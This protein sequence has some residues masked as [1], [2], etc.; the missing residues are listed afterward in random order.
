MAEGL[1]RAIAGDRFESHSAGTKPSGVNP[2]AIE[3]MR[4]VGIDISTQGSKNA[5]EYLGTRFPFIITVCDNAKEHC[6]IFPGPS[7]R[8][9]WSFEDP[10]DAVGSDEE[11][12]VVF[13][14]V[15]DQI[16]DRVREFVR[17]AT[18]DSLL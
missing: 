2:L 9:H 14:K 7:A 1:L 12:M 11:R 5:S 13:R 10:A 4:E 8:H 6:P 18:D 3:A 15:R 17:R 16:A